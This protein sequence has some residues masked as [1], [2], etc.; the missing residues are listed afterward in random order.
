MSFYLENPE[1][2]KKKQEQG[3]EFIKNAGQITML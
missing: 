3:H 2:I 1:L